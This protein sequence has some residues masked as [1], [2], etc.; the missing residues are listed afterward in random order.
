MYHTIQ[1]VI[2]R[3]QYLTVIYYEE[4]KPGLKKESEEQ[5][6]RTMWTNTNKYS[7]NR[8]IRRFHHRVR[9]S[10]RTHPEREWDTPRP[11]HNQE[12]Q[13]QCS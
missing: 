2:K 7:V 8:F 10:N 6:N 4:T 11:P 9:H 13:S 3:K 5:E 1:K 12:E